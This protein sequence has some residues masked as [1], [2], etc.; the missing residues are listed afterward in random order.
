MLYRIE[1]KAGVGWKW[2]VDA[3]LS[4]AGEQ[5]EKH[6]VE[7]CILVHGDASTHLRRKIRFVQ[8]LHKVFPTAP[9]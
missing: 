5:E 8:F 7:Y 1:W 3:G 4:I 6:Q 9:L 2:G